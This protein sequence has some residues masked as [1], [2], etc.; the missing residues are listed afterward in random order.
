MSTISDSY[1]VSGY[2]IAKECYSIFIFGS[3][4]GKERETGFGSSRQ[5]VFRIDYTLDPECT[6]QRTS[7]CTRVLSVNNDQNGTYPEYAVLTSDGNTTAAFR[8]VSS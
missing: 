8:I 6:W 2:L 3:N 4:D 5:I 7:L 1:L